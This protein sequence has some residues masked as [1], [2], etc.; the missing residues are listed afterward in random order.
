[1]PPANP[2]EGAQRAGRRELMNSR[3]VFCREHLPVSAT[4]HYVITNGGDQ[5][6]IVPDMASSVWYY[7]R[8]KDFASVRAPRPM[9]AMRSRDAAAKSTVTT[10]TREVL[11]TAAPINGNKVLAEAVYE[12][13]KAVGMPKWTADDQAFAKAVQE[14]N[15]LKPQPL[16]D[17]VMPLMPPRAIRN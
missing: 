10:V 1:M 17:A 11:G 2:W 6:N 7:F 16:A 8:D 9:R 12:N 4:F 15:N 5:L 3:L 13:I 14:V